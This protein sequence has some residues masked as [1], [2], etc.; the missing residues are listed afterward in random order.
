NRIHYLPL[1]AIMPLV[2]SLYGC[3]EQIN[4]TNENPTELKVDLNYRPIVHHFSSTGCGPCG[5]FGVPVLQQ[6]ANDMGDSIFAF[7]THF[8]YND[9]FITESSQSIEQGIL[10]EWYSPQ[11][12]VENKNITFDILGKDVQV[13]AED[14]KN[15]L[16][17]ETKK[18]AEAYIG[19]RKSLKENDRT[20]VEL[21]VKNATD[22][23]A[24]FYVEMY[25]MEDGIVASQAGPPSNV[26]TH[27]RVNRGGFYGQMGKEIK[28]A[29]NADFRDEF[30]YIPCWT[31]NPK[32]IYFNVIV[33]KK[34]SENKFE[35]VNGLEVR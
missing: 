1:I 29:A 9:P 24:T 21:V 20:D 14:V 18:S 22:Q 8:K 35:Y 15:L 27:M 25:G 2:F 3:K 7:I 10:A 13:A 4:E 19:L 28:L 26:I 30:E 16:R 31:C 11:I 12:W 34:N 5:R 32:A 6:V 33:W 23:V 17:S